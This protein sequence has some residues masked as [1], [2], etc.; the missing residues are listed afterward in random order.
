MRHNL[1]KKAS[2]KIV[3]HRASQEERIG[4]RR[5]RVYQIFLWHNGV[6]LEQAIKDFSDGPSI[7][8]TPL[9]H[10]NGW[11]HPIMATSFQTLFPGYA[12]QKFSVAIN[13]ALNLV[14]HRKNDLRKV[15]QTQW[16]DQCSLYKKIILI[17]FCI[18]IR[19]RE[20][21][22]LHGVL[23]SLDYSYCKARLFLTMVVLCFDLVFSCTSQFD[24][25]RP[26][27]GHA[28]YTYAWLLRT[29]PIYRQ[30][31]HLRKAFYVSWTDW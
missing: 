13:T 14:D 4:K 3:R 30:K 17:R 11:V 23:H 25:N 8:S 29:W 15:F 6:M 31:I 21:W 24:A 5:N 16:K 10:G 26:S 1:E 22:Y 28:P 18:V 9:R 2:G 12:P 7:K 27:P 19:H 20:V